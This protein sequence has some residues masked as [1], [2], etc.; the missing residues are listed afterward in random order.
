[1]F[2]FAN[3]GRV[4]WPVELPFGGG[5]DGNEPAT[6]HLLF[7]L[8]TDEEL[9]AREKAVLASAGAALAERVAETRSV[10]DLMAAME[11]V[12]EL[13]AADRA[14]IAARTL[15]WR[16]VVDADGQEVEFSAERLAA[17]LVHRPVFTRV[18]E[19]LFEASREGVRKN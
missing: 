1:M 15:A 4:W 10:D 17:L 2:R 3:L 12:V 16:G 5:E 9:M 13:K 8:L 14:E 18:R 19:A 7:V 11:S 6:I